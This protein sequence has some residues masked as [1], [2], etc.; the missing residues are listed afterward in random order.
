M[1]LGVT[2]LKLGE[3]GRVPLEDFFLTGSARKGLRYT[4][5]KL[6]REGCIFEVV[7]TEKVPSLLPELKRISDAWLGRKVV[8]EK[9]VSLG[10]FDA[11]YLERFPMG[12]V[13]KNDKIVAFANIWSGAE[14]EEVST[15]LMR[16]LLESP[17]G[18][19]EY[20]FIHLMLWSKNEGYR[21]F[22]LGMAP[23]S[24]IESRALAPL[25]NRIGAFVFRHGEHFYNLRG[26]R[27]FKEKFDPVWD[28]R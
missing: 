28:S 15:D 9:G 8:R 17:P 13:R 14:K 21:W 10:F 12:I 4:S 7:P 16:Y 1:D 6:E 27:Q 22:N 19:M 26:L 11:D 20:L 3:Q 18:V 5:H 2:L 25:W 23:F 24:G